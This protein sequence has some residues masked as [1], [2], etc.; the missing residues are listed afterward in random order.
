MVT[1]V[2]GSKVTRSR[3]SARTAPFG[4]SFIFRVT[5]ISADSTP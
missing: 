5:S 4:R 3:I 2:P 1:F